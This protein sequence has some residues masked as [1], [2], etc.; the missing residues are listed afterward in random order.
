MLPS[1]MQGW[2]GQGL[3]PQAHCSRDAKTAHVIHQPPPADY[4]TVSDAG[5]HG[6]PPPPKQTQTQ[7]YSDSVPSPCRL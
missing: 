3:T 2:R 1:C 4:E 7:T 5:V 6:P